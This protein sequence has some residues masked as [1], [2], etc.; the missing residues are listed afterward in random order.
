MASYAALVSLART[1]HLILQNHHHSILF[2]EFNQQIKNLLEQST[3]LQAFLEDFPDGA[4]S[5]QAQI[6]DVANEAEDVIE[7][8]LSKEMQK[9]TA[10]SRDVEST[11]FTELRQQYK[12]LKLYQKF[13]KVTEQI[14]TIAAKVVEI[15]NNANAR[16]I[17][18]MQLITYSS[19]T[20]VV[21]SS[22]RLATP[23]SADAIVGFED[24]LMAIKTQL[25]GQSSS[26]LQVIPIY[27]MGGIGKTTLPLNVY[28]DPLTVEHFD[29]RAWVTVSQDYSAREI[30]SNLLLSMK[31]FNTGNEIER[32]EERVYKTLKGRKYVIV[33]DDVWST[34]AWDAVKRIFPDDKNGSRIILTTRLL[35]VATYVCSSSYGPPHEMPF[36]DE[37]QSWNLLKTKVFK[38]DDCPKKFER[39]GQ[40]IARS[41]RGLPL[42][43]VVVAGLL[44][45]VSKT[46]ASWE[47]IA[48]NVNLAVTTADGNFTK[49]L[50]LSY[51][52]LPHHLR[53]C[54]LYLGSFPEDHE[55]NASKLIKLWVAEGF[56]KPSGSKSSEEVAEE[57]LEDLVKRSL[58]FV[59]KKKTNGRIKSCRLHDL[60]RDLCIRKAEEDKFLVHVMN[61]Y[62]VS[63]A[64]STKYQRRLSI[65]SDMI[66]LT[67]GTSVRSITCLLKS[68]SLFI[69]LK[70]CR[71][72][73]VLDLRFCDLGSFAAEL[74]ELLHLKYLACSSLMNPPASLSNLQN[75]Q[76]LHI[77]KLP[78]SK[79][80]LPSEIW[81]MGQLR[82]LYSLSF[83]SLPDPEG[84]TSPLE[85]LQTLSEVVDFKCTQKMVEM[86]PN[87]KKL[88]ISYHSGVNAPFVPQKINLTLPTTLKKLTLIR[89]LL[90]WKDT[91]IVGSLPNLEVLKLKNI[92]FFG[93]E[94]VTTEGQFPRLKFLLVD[95]SHLEHWITEGSHFP[96]LESLCLF[97]CGK[98]SEIPADIG[99]IPTLERIEVDHWNKSVA[100]SA[101]RIQE[102][103]Q[104]C[105][106]DTLQGC[107][108]VSS[109]HVSD[110][111]T[112][113]LDKTTSELTSNAQLGFMLCNSYF[114]F[115][116]VMFIRVGNFVNDAIASFLRRIHNVYWYSANALLKLSEPVSLESS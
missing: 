73:R 78:K 96:R 12:F 46:Q 59:T 100:E 27:G 87:L 63:E 70:G 71:L 47:N 93:P 64:E 65:T 2:H 34:K 86:T 85:N 31:I 79:L 88:G 7:H 94:W 19:S 58:V 98:L 49:I 112:G 13:Q 107:L 116:V 54:F 84:A 30:L 75:L 105:G 115:S 40:I 95:G 104:S 22:S 32:V 17:E 52:Y 35:D 53:P 50:S 76:T 51:T 99:E 33:M 90:P 67:S 81:R 60:V 56:L 20:A 4:D 44:A 102:E 68:T 106:N 111:V 28:D 61:R 14:D 18:V 103:Q 11:T 41:C 114:S 45:T 57:Y 69:S 97:R 16:R 82:H 80:R 89:P 15:M 39:I 21:G 72:L 37:T 92:A 6:R 66:C 48:Q 110:R 43:I 10:Q 3:L 24:E 36:L 83:D 23:P 26:K 9:S 5:L 8:F 109:D 55:L 91:E 1:I 62:G 108:Q 25:S 101:K 74:F 42:A 38:Q 77:L 29:I 113:W